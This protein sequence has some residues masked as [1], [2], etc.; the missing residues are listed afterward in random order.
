MGKEWE[1]MSIRFRRGEK[2]DLELAALITKVTMN[3]IVRKGTRE[4]IKN[5]VGLDEVKAAVAEARSQGARGTKEALKMAESVAAD[6]DSEGLGTV[7]A[8][9]TREKAGGR[10]RGAG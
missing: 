1:A 10:K 6:D 7:R 4:Y 9:R 3:D 5:V 2:D 8:V